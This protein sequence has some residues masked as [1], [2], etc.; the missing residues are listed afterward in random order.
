MRID[1]RDIRD[2]VIRLLGHVIDERGLTEVSLENHFYWVVPEDK[3]YNMDEKP[4]TLDVGS[5]AD[6]WQF[7]E[8]ILRDKNSPVA[9]SLTEIAPLLAF[10]GETASKQLARKGG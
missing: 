9:Y 4:S 8:A 5:L 1:L 10:I 7:V 6:D 2:V 3:K